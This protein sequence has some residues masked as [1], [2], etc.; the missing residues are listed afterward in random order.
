[1]YI[2]VLPS[3]QSRFNKHPS[4]LKFPCVPFVILY[5][6]KLRMQAQNQ[7]FQILK[8]HMKFCS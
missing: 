1:M 2:L 3:L 5:I 4:P 8:V 6:F 7:A